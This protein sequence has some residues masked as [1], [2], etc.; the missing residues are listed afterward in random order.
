LATQ[1]RPIQSEDMVNEQIAL[2]RRDAQREYRRQ[3]EMSGRSFQGGTSRND[4]SGKGG[5]GHG[6]ARSC[7]RTFMESMLLYYGIGVP[8]DIKYADK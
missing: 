3:L 8:I 1:I 2:V 6:Y 4:K 7:K 5:F